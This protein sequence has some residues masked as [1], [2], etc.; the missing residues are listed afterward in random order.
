MRKKNKPTTKLDRRIDILIRIVL[1]LVIVL[2]VFFFAIRPMIFKKDYYFETGNDV[3]L[4]NLGSDKGLDNYD[5]A[6][7]GDGIDGISAALGAANVGAKTLLVCSD[8][9]LGSQMGGS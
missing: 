4:E 5:I 3:T 1:V 7:I 6:V 8:K 9:E 2:I